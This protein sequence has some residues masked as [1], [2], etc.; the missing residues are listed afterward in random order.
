[1]R[2]WLHL[3]TGSH[4]LLRV[5]IDEA[6]AREEL[7]LANFAMV[8][9]VKDIVPEV[10]REARNLTITPPVGLLNI[11]G[12]LKSQSTPKKKNANKNKQKPAAK[13]EQTRPVV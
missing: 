13:A 6:A 5:E 12:L 9:F 11:Q 2:E 8:P 7:G 3:H 4:D 10:D 1:M